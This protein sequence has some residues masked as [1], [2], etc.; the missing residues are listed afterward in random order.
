[1]GHVRRGRLEAMCWMLCRKTSHVGMRSSG[2]LGVR[3]SPQAVVSNSCHAMCRAR[4]H[5]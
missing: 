3:D 1:M 4:L 2:R 5:V